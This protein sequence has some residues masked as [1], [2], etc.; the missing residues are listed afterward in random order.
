MALHWD[1]T[2]MQSPAT[3]HCVRIRNPPGYFCVSLIL[4]QSKATI[5]R[6]AATPARDWRL[7]Q[8]RLAIED[9]AVASYLRP[10]REL[11]PLDLAAIEDVLD[12]DAG[13][14]QIVGD[15]AAMA[16]P[17]HGFGAHEGDP[18][19]AGEAQEVIERAA[20]RLGL[21]VVGVV[22]EALLA[23]ERVRRFLAV[24]PLPAPPAQR[25]DMAI[26]DARRGQRRGE[27]FRVELRMAPRHR[28]A[29]HIDDAFDPCLAQQGEELIEAAR[30]MPD[31]EDD[32]ARM[33]WSRAALMSRHRNSRN[34][35]P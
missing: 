12:R 15:E 20:E 6:T 4:S 9:R 14:E 27:R 29:P 24:R 7:N 21:G 22:A 32:H 30:R 28:K 16:A 35:T 11:G 5:A 3:N 2:T 13:G 31:G 17:P 25:R 34:S 19:L 23:P 8:P 1:R 10:G 26:A 18:L 33:M